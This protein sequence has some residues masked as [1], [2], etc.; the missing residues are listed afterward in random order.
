MSNSTGLH[1]S[2]QGRG[3]T[4]YILFVESDDVHGALDTDE[5][6][7]LARTKSMMRAHPCSIELKPKYPD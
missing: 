7:I 1:F 2:D 4:L 5:F 3:A 6:T